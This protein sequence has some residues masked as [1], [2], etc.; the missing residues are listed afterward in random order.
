[1]SVRCAGT[2]KHLTER[3]GARR[4]GSRTESIDALPTSPLPR[5]AVLP[6]VRGAAT[7]IAMAPRRWARAES[8]RCCKSRSLSAPVGF[9]IVI[10]PGHHPLCSWRS[11]SLS[12]LPSVASRLKAPLLPPAQQVRRRRPEILQFLS[13]A[14]KWILPLPSL[15]PC[16]KKEKKRNYFSARLDPCCQFVAGFLCATWCP[17]NPVQPFTRGWIRFRLCSS[18]R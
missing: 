5:W 3:E 12:I 10:I 6:L 4:A 17:V 1:M 8:S 9:P 16:S 2:R 15:S 14:G 18:K 7:E 11:S 13:L